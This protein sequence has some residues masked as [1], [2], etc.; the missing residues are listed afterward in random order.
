MIEN[1]TYVPQPYTNTRTHTYTHKKQDRDGSQIYGASGSP[2]AI[3]LQIAYSQTSTLPALADPRPPH[4]RNAEDAFTMSVDVVEARNLA[5]SYDGDV[6]SCVSLVREPALMQ[7][8]HFLV[9]DHCE[10]AVTSDADL[11][12]IPQV[13]TSRVSG[14]ADPQ[15]TDSR[16]LRDTHPSIGEI[17]ASHAHGALASSTRHVLLDGDAVLMLVTVSLCVCSFVCVC[18]CVCVSW[19]V[20][21]HL[22]C[23]RIWRDLCFWCTTSFFPMEKRFSLDDLLCT[24]RIHTRPHINTYTHTL[25]YTYI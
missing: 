6:I 23:V 11:R 20:M 9:L 18:V 4:P 7:H 15:W 10:G 24:A 19:R 17:E 14:T 21:T 2:S 1:C 25:M 3:R 12:L 5:L 22:K 8:N 16:V 13:T